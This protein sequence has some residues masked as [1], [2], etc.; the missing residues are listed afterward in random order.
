[1][2]KKKAEANFLASLIGI[3]SINTS[4]TSEKPKFKINLFPDGSA[5]DSSSTT[6]LNQNKS[7]DTIILETTTEESS[8]INSDIY[9]IMNSMSLDSGDSKPEA[10]AKNND[11]ETDLLGLM[12]MF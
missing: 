6:T 2:S 5:S 8:K 9:G 12:D 1:M 7:D 11:D 3:D 10:H 4:S